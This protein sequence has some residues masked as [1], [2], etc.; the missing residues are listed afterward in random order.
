MAHTADY[1]L[2]QFKTYDDYLQSY[3]AI[4]DQ[5]YLSNTRTQKNLVK[6]GYSSNGQLHEEHEFYRLKAKVLDLINPKVLG[7][8]KFGKYRKHGEDPVLEALAAREEMNLIQKLSTIIFVLIRQTTGF[9]ISGYIDYESSLRHCNMKSRG[10]TDWKAIFEGRKPLRP[11]RSDLSYLD[12][13]NKIVS[14]NDSDNYETMHHGS[15]LMFKHKGDHKMIPVDL[16]FTHFHQ[17]VK[18]TMIESDFMG[19]VVLYDHIVRKPGAL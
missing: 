6:L 15:A 17:N 5:R 9:D 14:F 19:T 7:S 13:H 12:W 18:R 10:A 8:Q 4:E 3:V 11:R 16:K 2:L 1:G